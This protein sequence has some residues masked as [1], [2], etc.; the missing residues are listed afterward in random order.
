MKQQN[1]YA[2]RKH[3]ISACKDHF[4]YILTREDNNV[5]E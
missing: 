5:F 3:D 4:T 1:I 2:S